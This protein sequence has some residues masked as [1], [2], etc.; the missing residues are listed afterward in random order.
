M[1]HLVNR[2][3]MVWVGFA[4]IALLLVG[5]VHAEQGITVNPVPL[6]FTGFSVSDEMRTLEITAIENVTDLTFIPL[7]LTS[8]DGQR[9]I[10]QQS[11]QAAPFSS[12][13][14]NGSIQQIPVTF[15]LAGSGHYTGEMWFSSSGSGIAKVPV[16]A[17]VKDDWE[18]P[19]AV[20]LV[21]IVFSFFLITYSSDFKKRDEI[22]TT[23]AVFSNLVISDQDLKTTYRLSPQDPDEK[24][25]TGFFVRINADINQVQLKLDTDAISDAGTS[26]TNVKD[27]WD[28][29]NTNKARFMTLFRR[30]EELV[31]HMNDL[32]R[33]TGVKAGITGDSSIPVIR[34]MRDDI[35]KNFVA[36]SLK[37]SGEKLEES[38]KNSE[39]S[40]EKLREVVINLENL[41]K[42]CG[43]IDTISCTTCNDLPEVWNSLLLIK[44]KDEIK[45][46]LDNIGKWTKE[47]VALPKKPISHGVKFFNVPGVLTLAPLNPV[48]V[49][50]AT[51]VNKVN[52]ATA[53]L[54][55]FKYGTYLGTIVLVTLYGML[56]IYVANPTFGSTGDYIN[57]GI[58]GLIAGASADAVQKKAKG[59]TGIE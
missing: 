32:E 58:W 16:T 22:Q 44:N 29:W 19:L 31:A 25:H 36:V 54:I 1:K 48:K 45:E 43:T 53:R 13:M 18:L 49:P 52:V 39:D 50:D 57:I 28:N 2:K 37:D 46:K 26:L 10:H 35:R 59:L 20:L 38:I 3:K 56:Q 24:L 5:S 21:G 23:L 12:S 55:L 42:L 40:Y 47:V 15:K 51:V 8:N 9:V 33:Q 4:I 34:S 17:T 41:E 27:S 14:N 30:A 7:D 6:N 11:I